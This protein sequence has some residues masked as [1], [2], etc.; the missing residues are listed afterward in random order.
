LEEVSLGNC[1]ILGFFPRQGRSL[2]ST[3]LF[4]GASVFAWWNAFLVP[5]LP[6]PLFCRLRYR[7]TLPDLSEIMALRGIEISH[8]AV[9]DWE[10]ALSN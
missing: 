6:G 3:K 5:L 4:A 8:E 2:V 10:A 1:L 7:L 9:R